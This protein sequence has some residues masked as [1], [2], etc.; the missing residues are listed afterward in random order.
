MNA[1]R[2]LQVPAVTFVSFCAPLL[3]LE[4]HVSPDGDDTNPGSPERPVAGLHRAQEILRSSDQR[5]SEPIDIILDE[6]IHYLGKPLLLEAADSG[7]KDAPVTLR[8]ANGKTAVLSGGADLGNLDWKIHQGQIL[9]AKVPEGTAIDILYVNG[10][11]MPMARYPNF[12]PEA[13]YFNGTA[14]DAFSKEKAAE[15]KNPAGGFMHAMHKAKWGGMHYRITGKDDNGELTHEGGWQ[16]NRPSPPHPDIRFVENIFE[17]LDAPREWFLDTETHTLYF[18]A[19]KGLDLSKATFQ[20]ARLENL[21]ELR[22]TEESPAQ[23]IQLSGLTFT[24]A[25]RTFMKN[26]ERLLRT[27]WT[28]NR[29]AAVFINGAEDCLI[30]NCHVREVGGNAIFVNHYNRRITIRG[31]HIEQA[32]GNGIAIIG[33][34]GAVRDGLVGYGSRTTYEKLDKTPGPK[35]NNYP[36]EVLVE[37]CLI[38]DIGRVEKQTAGVEIDI[39]MHITVRHVTVHDVPRAGINIGAGNF[40]GHVIDFCDVFDTVMETGDHGSFNSWG[41]DR[42]WKLKDVPNDEM[43]AGKYK[44]LPLLDVIHP[45]TISNSRWR[46][47]HGWDIDL[48][49][50]SSNY[51]I[52]NNLCLNGGIKNREGFLRTVENNIMVNNSLHPHVWYK[53]SGDI[54]RRNIVFDSYRPA[55][56]PDTP[57]GKEFDHNLYVSKDKTGPALPLAGQSKRDEHSIY[58]DPGFLDPQAGDYRVAQDSPALKL[59]FKNFPMDRFGVTSPRLKKLARS[60]KLPIPGDPEQKKSKR[61]RREHQWLGAKVKNIVGM[62][63]VSAT[64]LPDEIGVRL[65]DVPKDSAAARHGLQKSDVIIGCNGK[66]T[67]TF[68][69]LQGHWHVSNEDVELEIWRGQ[70]SQ[71]LE[72]KKD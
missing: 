72:I 59:G 46:C 20:T 13:Q 66:K 51:H 69:D 53:H 44:D 38:H 19:P 70:E 4:I 2:I 36:A 45:I 3:A 58:G 47:D 16:N 52:F 28:V 37:D 34:Q 31:C 42:F 11:T 43:G 22:G 55:I 57:W 35:T 26:K 21:V 50:G 64:G 40:G 29:S 9:M 1:S 18:F 7:S 6:G 49:D 61:D 25:A 56:M 32:G 71:M 8:A 41:R 14:A 60:P 33:G 15:W 5:G 65:L 30:Q 62:G 27:D 17:E 68:A 23:H 54:F 63:E 67:D 12:D 10:K 48:D 24:H 39:A